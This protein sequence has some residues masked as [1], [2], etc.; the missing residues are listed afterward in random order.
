MTGSLSAG[1][2]TTSFA[3]TD[4]WEMNI[5]ALLGGVCLRLVWLTLLPKW[6]IVEK[7]ECQWD[8]ARLDW[9]TLR[10]VRVFL[11]LISETNGLFSFLNSAN[12]PYSGILVHSE[13]GL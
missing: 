5:N 10:S 3:T 4:G 11:L 8:H 9:E 2:T 13:R 1:L 7:Q 6:R 12:S